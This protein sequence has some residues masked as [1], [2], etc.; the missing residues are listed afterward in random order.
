MIKGGPDVEVLTG[1]AL[2]GGLPA[3]W[4]EAAVTAAFVVDALRGHWRAEGVPPFALFDNDT[5]FQGA[6][7]FPDTLGRVTRCCLQ[8]SVVP[9]FAPP[10]EPGFQGALEN[11]NGRGQAK[12]WARFQHASLAAL[13]ACSARYIAAYRRRGAARLEA[14]P[15]RRPFPPAWQLD[16]QAPPEGVVIFLRRTDPQGRV[17]LLGH[18]LDVGP[19]WPHRLVRAEVGL[20]DGPIRLFGLR[21]REPTVQPLLNEVPYH[22]P[23]R[24]WR[25]QE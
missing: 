16:L 9:V 13:Q 25:L 17:A 11:F 18:T 14:A 12:V 21:R 3:A 4:P 22:L 1:L 7:N 24:R 15:P 23:K 20:P 2:R 10:R 6:H 19:H 8:L 5:R